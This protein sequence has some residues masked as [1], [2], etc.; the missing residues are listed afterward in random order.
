MKQLSDS[1]SRSRVGVNECLVCCWACPDSNAG[2]TARW[3]CGSVCMV[4][5]ATV[6]V[7]WFFA[8][9]M[10][11]LEVVNLPAWG[12]LNRDD[13][14]DL[15]T[16]GMMWLVVMWICLSEK[17]CDWWWCRSAYVVMWLCWCVN[18]PYWDSLTG[19][20]VDLPPEEWCDGGGVVDLPAW[21]MMRL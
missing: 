2:L 17:Y 20:D 1:A 13:E 8:W 4:G 7:M 19:G 6:T 15:P 18:L 10:R 5:D 21:G 9:W 14:L 11:Y 16:L 3:W 12:I